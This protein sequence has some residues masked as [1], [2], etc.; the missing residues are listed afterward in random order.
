MVQGYPKKLSV[1]KAFTL[2]ELL[3]VIAIIAIL[4]ALILPALSSAKLKAW[5]VSCL[6][7]TR[8]LA[9]MAITYQND[10]GKGLP[11][12]AG[13]MP[14]W[15][16]ALEWS[17]PVGVIVPEAPDVS[18][19]PLAKDLPPGMH[20]QQG[21]WYGNN[22]GTAANCWAVVGGDAGKI[23]YT[24][25][26]YAANDWFELAGAPALAGFGQLNG[27]GNLGFPTAAS[28]RYPAQTP[29]FSDGTWKIVTPQMQEMPVDLFG[30]TGAPAGDAP[31]P[32]IGIVT[33]ARHGSKPP[34][35]AYLPANRLAAL[36]RAW[37]VNVS[38][39]DGHAE[40][41]KLPDLWELTWNRT[42]NPS[43]QAGLPAQPGRP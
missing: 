33:I 12:N 37:G 21:E 23:T 25:G 32:T 36:P 15:S 8:Q 3:V 17:D 30:G 22:H 42:W 10:Y 14:V 4:A 6:S 27:S 24:T 18:I 34:V 9:L 13:N 2:V 43:V 39:D 11:H 26:S 7:N 41:V 38:F 16:R 1:N 35:H 29:L 19:C 31:E 5:Q 28:V 20:P 40:L